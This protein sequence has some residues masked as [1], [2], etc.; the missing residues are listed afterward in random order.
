M[1][2]RRNLKMP[3]TSFRKFSKWQ[4]DL[5]PI[6]YQSSYGGITVCWNLLPG[7]RLDLDLDDGRRKTVELNNDGFII[8]TI[9][10][11]STTIASVKVSP[12]PK[13]DEINPNNPKSVASQYLSYRYRIFLRTTIL[14]FTVMLLYIASIAYLWIVPSFWVIFVFTIYPLVCFADLYLLE[15]RIRRGYFG[16]T[17]QEIRD[18]LKF[19]MSADDKFDPGNGGRPPQILEPARYES[20]LHE[21]A[22]ATGD[23]AKA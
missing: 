5:Q 9:D 4:K 13:H 20:P 1:L 7:V 23:P 10:G 21:V 8:E 18:L 6:T 3:F 15:Y 19:I 22:P 12:S 14:I 11:K 17:K 16:R 2:L